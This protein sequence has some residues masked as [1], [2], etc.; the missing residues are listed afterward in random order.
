MRKRQKK[1]DFYQM[2]I[3]HAEMT[4]KGLEILL[5]YCEDK[6]PATAEEVI[7]YEEKADGLRREMVIALNKTFVTPIDREDIFKLSSAVDD[8][9]D[10]AKNAILA[11]KNYN[12]EP[13]SYFLRMSTILRD[14]ASGLYKAAK[15]FKNNKEKAAEECYMVKKLENKANRIYMEALSKLFND[16]DFK[17]ILIYRELYRH[18]NNAADKG[19]NAADIFLN[20]IV[21]I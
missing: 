2:I 1:I 18:L 3:D 12:V 9:I 13:D 10:Y 6:D 4:Y 16:D 21:K 5:K 7:A 19:D 15:L 14:I 8:V 17:K 11:L 20:I